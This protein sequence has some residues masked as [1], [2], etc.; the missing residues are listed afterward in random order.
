M[1]IIM[2]GKRKLTQWKYGNYVKKLKKINVKA[3][4]SPTTQSMENED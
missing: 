1:L 2:Q 3:N 4:N